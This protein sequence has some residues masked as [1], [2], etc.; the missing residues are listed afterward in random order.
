MTMRDERYCRRQ[1]LFSSAFLGLSI[2]LLST[3]TRAGPLFELTGGNQGLGGFNARIAGASSASAYFNP[4]LLP[5]A[6]PGLELGIFTLNDQ[7]SID[8][9]RRTGR[10]YDVPEGVRL[11]SRG[12]NSPLSPTP[13]PTAWLQEGVQGNYERDPRPRQGVNSSDNTRVYQIVGLVNRVFDQQLAIGLH[14]MIPLAGFTAASAFYNDEKE[15]FF[16]NSLHAELYS[17]RLAAA[18][19]AFGLAGRVYEKLSIG[20]SFTLNL[21]NEAVTPVYV[22]D[23]GR[24]YDTYIDSRIDVTTAVSPHFGLVFDAHERVRLTATVHTPQSMEIDTDFSYLLNNGQEQQSGIS[25]VHGFLPWSAALGASYDVLVPST[26]ETR[27]NQLSLV[28][29]LILADWTD[30][31][32][33]HGAK[34]SAKYEWAKTFTPSLGVRHSY[35][36]FGTF[37][38]MV[39][40]PTP[41]PRQTG[42]T[43]Y[44][45]ND[46]MGFVGGVTYCFNLLNTDFRAG[47]QL[48]LHRLFRRIQ[49]KL[50]AGDPGYTKNEPEQMVV[51]EVPDDAID[52]AN[53]GA[54]AEGREGLQTNNPGWPGFSSEGYLFGGGVHFAFL[55]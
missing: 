10:R 24:L 9:L 54:A 11:Y 19:L 33:R 23:A 55:F 46:R 32:D 12:D 36:G 31:R 38:D 30:Y 18:E 2:L 8:V 5:F 27:E 45:D 26:P 28:G 14:A 50:E 47:L 20:M 29:S 37:L 41:V 49:R 6:E 13:L 39:Y 17:D 15:Q 53:L 34:A 51:D 43:N 3:P 52:N 48:Q 16:S 1:V 35:A 40:V 7:I 42:R 25:F 44:V 4:A 22:S 21:K